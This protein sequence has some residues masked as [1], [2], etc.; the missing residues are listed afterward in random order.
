MHPTSIHFQ[1]VILESANLMYTLSTMYFI[2]IIVLLNH[3]LMTSLFCTSF[4]VTFVETMFKQLQSKIEADMLN[5]M[6]FFGL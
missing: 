1:I 6:Y 4:Y 5:V 3:L 2:P